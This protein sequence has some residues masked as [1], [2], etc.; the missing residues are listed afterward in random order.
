MFQ[1][2]DAVTYG[3][4]GACRITAEETKN[5]GG[6]SMT[7]LVLKPVY[8][9]SLTICVPTAS[10]AAKAKMRRLMT[11]DE[12][13]ALIQ[14]MPEENDSYAADPGVR[15]EFYNDALRSGDR[16]QLV[17]MIKSIYRYKQDRLANGKHL[18]TFDETAMREAETMLYT[19]FAL[20]LGMQ[21]A[22]VVPFIQEQIGAACGQVQ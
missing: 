16:R 2:G 6:Q 8:D 15:R 21:P 4:S 5:I 17:R 10:E 9:S 14:N 13:Y 3:T 7:C 20:V 1:V 11:K 22:E 12:A 18:A 19:E